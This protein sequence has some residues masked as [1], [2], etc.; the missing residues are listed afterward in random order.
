MPTNYVS[1]KE[2]LKFRDDAWHKY[3]SNP[4]FLNLV[5]NKFGEENMNNVI[6]QSKI[7]L[8]KVTW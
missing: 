8:K 2:V 5:K 1:S 4:N 3:F 7:R 6:K